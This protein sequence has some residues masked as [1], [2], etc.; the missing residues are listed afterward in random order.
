MTEQSPGTIAVEDFFTRQLPP[1][2]E[3]YPDATFKETFN[4]EPD[5]EQK[6]L[7]ELQYV[8]NHLLHK[9]CNEFNPEKRDELSREAKDVLDE[10]NDRA[11]DIMIK[12]SNVRQLLMMVMSK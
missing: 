2:E 1:V 7:D 5:Q 3:R 11:H 12:Q 10:W 8:F 4:P 9:A 6:D